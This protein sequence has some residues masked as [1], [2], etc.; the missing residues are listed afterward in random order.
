M[1]HWDVC[2]LS[3]LLYIINWYSVHVNINEVF[4]FHKTVILKKSSTTYLEMHLPYNTVNWR[5]HQDSC[6]TTTEFHSAVKHKSVSEIKINF[7]HLC[8]QRVSLRVA[9]GHISWRGYPQGVVLFKP[10]DQSSHS[11]GIMRK[12]EVIR[13]R[14]WMMVHYR[15]SWWRAQKVERWKMSSGAEFLVIQFDFLHFAAVE[16]GCKTIFWCSWWNRHWSL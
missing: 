11:T 15:W 8:K 1:D 14:L 7:P 4:K 12:I 13:I 9:S 3:I 6:L 2:T 16:W 5:M 10:L